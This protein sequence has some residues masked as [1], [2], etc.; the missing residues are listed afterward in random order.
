MDHDD[1]AVVGEL[2]DSATL[3]AVRGEMARK[4]G[5]L[6]ERLSRDPLGDVQTAAELQEFAKLMASDRAAQG[7]A[8]RTRLSTVLAGGGDLP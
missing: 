1:S 4:A 3:H 6:V 8:A 2:R 7:R 5:P